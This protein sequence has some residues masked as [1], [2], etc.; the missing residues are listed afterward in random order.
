M[1]EWAATSIRSSCC[2]YCCRRHCR[3]CRTRRCC[4]NPQLRSLR[5]NS[6]LFFAHR[7]SSIRKDEFWPIHDFTYFTIFEFTRIIKKERLVIFCL[8][9]IRIQANQWEH[10][11]TVPQIRSATP[12]SKSESLKYRWCQSYQRD[13]SP[14]KIGDSLIF[15]YLLSLLNLD[16]DL[17]FD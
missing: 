6:N 7:L 2:G 3:S 4:N 8:F 5:V 9:L 16:E 14:P 10:R 11:K 17:H 12:P 15:H 13:F 1:A